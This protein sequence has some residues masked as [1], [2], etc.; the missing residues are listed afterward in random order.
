MQTFIA[1][2]LSSV[3]GAVIRA[4]HDASERHLRFHSEILHHAAA[5]SE[6]CVSHSAKAAAAFR[7]P[8]DVAYCLAASRP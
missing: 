4:F 6:T 8:L 1:L 3:V 5:Q 2:C 7:H